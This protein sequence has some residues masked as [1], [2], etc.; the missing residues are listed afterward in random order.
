MSANFRLRQHLGFIFTA[1]TSDTCTTT[2]FHPE[3]GMECKVYSEGTLPAGLAVETTYWI[4]SANKAAGTFKLS[5]TKGGAAV[6]IT[7]TGSGTHRIFV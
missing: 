1:A 4:V 2:N 5:A 3:D 7:S 6:D